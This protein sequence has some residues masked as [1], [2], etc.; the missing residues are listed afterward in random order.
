MKC[1]PIH[2][3]QG[4][5]LWSP[6]AGTEVS[7]RGV[8]TGRTRKGFFLQDPEGGETGCSHAVFV[9]SPDRKPPIDAFVEV[10]GRVTDFL[11]EKTDRPTTQIHAVDTQTLNKNGPRLKPVWLTAERIALE[12]DALAVYL[13]SLEG[14]LVGIEAGATFIAPKRP[15]S[16]RF[17]CMAAT[18]SRPRRSCWAAKTRS[19]SGWRRF[20]ACPRA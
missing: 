15:R 9:F 4:T 10:H 16:I 20:S 2:E 7:A 1:T 18:K 19:R 12:N 6:L 14:M 11:L 13:N 5:N 3:I 8:V 17:R